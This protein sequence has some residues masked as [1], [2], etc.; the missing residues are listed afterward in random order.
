MTNTLCD[1]VLIKGCK[2]HNSSTLKLERTVL[3]YLGANY[4][5]PKQA[6]KSIKLK[7]STRHNTNFCKTS[8]MPTGVLSN[9]H[10]NVLPKREIALLAYKECFMVHLRKLEIS[11]CSSANLIPCVLTT[12]VQKNNNKNC[13]C[14]LQSCE[15]NE[16][17]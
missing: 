7:L 15:A 14:L 13:G 8:L 10:L 12:L 2:N 9:V 5:K 3:W 4:H 6:A 1:I 16:K 17:V 11:P